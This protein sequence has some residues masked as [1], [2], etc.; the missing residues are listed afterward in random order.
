MGLATLGCKVNQCE[1]AAITEML[2]KEGFLPVPFSDW[3]DCYIVNTCTVTGRTDFQSRQL[4]RRALRKNPAAF[5]V[6]TGCYAQRASEEIASLEGVSLVVGN[7]GKG[8]IPALIKEGVSR[9]RVLVTPIA[10]ERTI[11]NLRATRFPGHTRAFLKIQDGCDAFC[12]YCIVPYARGRSRSLPVPEVMAQ[13]RNLSDGGHREVV[14]TGVHLGMYGLDLNPPTTLLSLLRRLEKQRPVERIRLS[15]LEPG[16]LSDEIISL[17]AASELICHH[18]HIPLQSGDDAILKA[19]GRNYDSR[20]FRERIEKA[21]RTIDDCAVGVDVMVGF[22]GEGEVQFEN[23]RRL[24]DEMALAY[25]HVFPYSRRPGT[26]AADMPYQVKEEDKKRRAKGLSELGERKREAFLSRSIG[27]EL[28]VLVEGKRDRDT[29][30]WQ[31]FSSNYISCL[32][33]GADAS[34]VNKIVAVK[35]EE[36]IGRKLVGRMRKNG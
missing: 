21:V 11:A 35:A 15:S 2:E 1:T 32:I 6:V 22:P 33:K 10:S 7:G 4:V 20:F 12:S 30:L 16:E 34:L 19:M 5:V 25:L 8:S 31:G 17:V 18:L 13:L 28:S 9:R 14:L 3:A 27:K 23:T 26:A 24:L 29:G 36:A